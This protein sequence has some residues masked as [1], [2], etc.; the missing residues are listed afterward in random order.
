M[1]VLCNLIRADAL[2]PP[3]DISSL[4]LCGGKGERFGNKDKPL[5]LFDGE[6][7]PLP[8][9]DYA[10][11]VF[12]SRRAIISANRNIGQYLK[13]GKVI[14]DSDFGLIGHGPDRHLCWSDCLQRPGCWFVLA[15]CLYYPRIGIAVTKGGQGE[16]RSRVLHD[17]TPAVTFVPLPKTLAQDLGAFVRSSV[18]LEPGIGCASCDCAIRRPSRRVHQYQ[19]RSRSARFVTYS[20]ICACR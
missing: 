20:P 8:M 10:I 9:V 15:I 7:G 19:Q 16:P 18:P 2:I 4:V 11:T 3:G 1:I 6:L 13:R 17:E 5:V 12:L 14:Q